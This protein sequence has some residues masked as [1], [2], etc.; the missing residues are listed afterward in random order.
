MRREA[1]IKTKFVSDDP[2]P[3]R[4][5]HREVTDILGRRHGHLTGVFGLRDW[6]LTSLV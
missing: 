6:S 3:T 4:E 5:H 2:L 1:V